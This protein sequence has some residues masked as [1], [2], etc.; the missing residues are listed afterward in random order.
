MQ[1]RLNTIFYFIL[2]AGMILYLKLFDGTSQY[3]DGNSII[4]YTAFSFCI[5]ATIV[6]NGKIKN[7]FLEMLIILILS[8]YYLRIPMLACPG[9]PTTLIRISVSSDLI[10][11]KMLEL[12]YHYLALSLAIIIIKPKIKGI[13]LHLDKIKAGRLLFLSS[14][15]LF[16]TIAQ[17]ELFGYSYRGSNAS[18]GH[19][20][21]IISIFNSGTAMLVVIT[22]IVAAG[23][24]ISKGHKYWAFALII[25]N[26]GYYCYFGSKGPI[27][28][29]LLQIIVARLVCYGPI[30][31]NI[32]DMIA[33]A[34]L[35]PVVLVNFFVANVMRYYQRG[36]VG[37]SAVINAF[38]G[39][40]EH[41]S[42]TVFSLSCR[43]G[44]FDYY[45]ESSLNS[46]YI[47]YISFKYYFK[48]IMDK[49]TPG[50][51]VFN[52]S[53]A[54][55]MFEYARSG[56]ISLAMN[57][58]QVTLFGETSVIFS[59]L[60]VIMFFVFMMFFKLL[61]KMRPSKDSFM[62]ILYLVLVFSAYFYWI[63]GFG[64]DTFFVLEL[65]YKF[66]FFFGLLWLYRLNFRNDK[67]VR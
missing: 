39:A 5:L 18:L 62:N 60:S 51:S 49:L 42:D 32:R 3:L 66:V 58:D 38:L 17:V 10:S 25:I 46:C 34:V 35:F 61:I 48:S 55:K 37:T 47:S 27:I 53:F 52:V 19:F 12:C 56:N 22:Y 20:V 30:V 50:F 31:L 16:L 26:V 1:I 29:V 54:S 28:M 67:G 11:Q 41:I 15:M 24:N 44:F 63:N 8:C 9:V 36:Q 6:I 64:F 65:V 21:A 33:L 45:V 59:Y 23:R 40:K 2:A 57:S 13:N 43:T 4:Y 7:I 14:I